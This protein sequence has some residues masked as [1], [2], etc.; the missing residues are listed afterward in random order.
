MDDII[1]IASKIPAI[2]QREK[3]FPYPF[4][5]RGKLGVCQTNDSISFTNLKFKQNEEIEEMLANYV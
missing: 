3:L 4:G 1:K 5:L 2:R